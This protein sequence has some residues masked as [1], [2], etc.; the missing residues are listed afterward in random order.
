M[1]EDLFEF[2]VNQYGEG[3]FGYVA[4][5]IICAIIEKHGKGIA[6]MNDMEIHSLMNE[7]AENNLITYIMA[8]LDN[9]II[10][11]MMIKD[12]RRYSEE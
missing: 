12:I 3:L 1:R 6:D 11:E 5:E 10:R 2:M 8:N 9:K 7:F 4:A